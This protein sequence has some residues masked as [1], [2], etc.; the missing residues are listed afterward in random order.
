MDYYSD[1]PFILSEEQWLP[2]SLKYDQTILPYIQNEI[3]K[4][5]GYNPSDSINNI[6]VIDNGVNIYPYRYFDAITQ[7]KD[8]FCRHHAMGGWRNRDSKNLDPLKETLK[9]IYF[10]F[11]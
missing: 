8:S 10:R 5:H 1:R 6:Q 2:D 4:L 9:K 11:I 3:A 7:K